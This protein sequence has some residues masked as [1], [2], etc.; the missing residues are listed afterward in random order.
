M[1]ERRQR[2]RYVWANTEQALFLS[3]F[4]PSRFLQMNNTCK[5]FATALMGLSLCTTTGLFAQAVDTVPPKIVCKQYIAVSPCNGIRIATLYASDLLQSVTDNV[6]SV[7]SIHLGIRKECTGD[8]FPDDKIALDFTIAELGNAIVEL[9]A[10][11][12]ASNASYCQTNVYIGAG[13][14]SCDPGF[15]FDAYSPKDSAFIQN[16][17]ADVD[18]IT[19]QNDSTHA[20]FPL[21]LHSFGCLSRPGDLLFVTP[22][23]SDHPLNGVSTY[24]LALISKYILGLATLSPYQ[25]IAADANEDGKVTAFDIVLLRQLILGI[26]TELPKGASWRFIPYDYQFPDPGNP[27]SPPFPTRIE[28]PRSADPS[29]NYFGFFGVKIGDVNFSADLK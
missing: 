10:R 7:S 16:A 2:G 29:P 11:D 3:C 14:G 19:C 13:S 5:S 20:K 18:K 4:W 26:I 24:D 25:L 6:S 23:K 27:F 12:E 17:R 1:S 9:W 15:G 8:G 21:P 22:S 28:V